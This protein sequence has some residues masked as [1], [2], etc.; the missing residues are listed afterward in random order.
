[1]KKYAFAALFLLSTLSVNSGSPSLEN[2]LKFEPTEYNLEKEINK[3]LIKLYKLSLE[4]EEE[5]EKLNKI[6]KKIIKVFSQ[7]ERN[8]IALISN[9]LN[10]EQKH[11]YRLMNF[12]CGFNH[13]KP[14]PFSNAIGLIQFLPSTAK[15]LGTSTEELSQMTK[16]EQ[17]DYVY[18]YLN[19]YCKKHNI[20]TYSDLYLAVFSPYSLDK[21][22]DFVIGKKESKLVRENPIFDLNKDGEITKQEIIKKIS[23]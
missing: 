9:K 19:K 6:N 1:M 18:K 17:L 7:E 3:Q 13:T 16:L 2:N 10:I 5:Q 22:N 23:M 12:E 14:N 4:Q 8:K 15:K 21:P 20:K 11:L